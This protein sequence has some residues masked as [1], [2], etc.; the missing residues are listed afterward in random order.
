MI[1]QEDQRATPASFK[2]S[3]RD[4]YTIP[5]EKLPNISGIE[6]RTL[7]YNELSLTQR[8]VTREGLDEGSVAAIIMGLVNKPYERPCLDT[9]ADLHKRMVYPGQ[10]L[11]KALRSLHLLQYDDA[12][13]TIWIV[14]SGAQKV[15]AVCQ[16]R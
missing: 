6:L 11:Q 2:K 16:I 8:L 12:Q 13:E 14:Y 9:L 7:I 4:D 10:Y 1:L 5:T 15:A 3:V